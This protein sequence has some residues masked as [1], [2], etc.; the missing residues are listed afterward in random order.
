MDEDVCIMKNRI[1]RLDLAIKILV[2]RI[3]SPTY[4]PMLEEKEDES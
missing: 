1:D 4:G 2:D 3:N